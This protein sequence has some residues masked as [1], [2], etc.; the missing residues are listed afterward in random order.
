VSPRHKNTSRVRAALLAAV[1]VTLCLGPVT[2]EASLVI[3]EV[4]SSSLH[5]Q[6]T[7]PGTGTANGDWWELTN[8][9]P[10]QVNV[11]GYS[12]ADAD[13]LAGETPFPAVSI[14]VGE[15]VVIVNENLDNIGGF[16]TA[17]GLPGSVV[18][19]SKDLFIGTEGFHKFSSNGDEVNLFDPDDT[20]VTMVSFGVANPGTTFEWARGGESLGYSVAGEYGAY[21]APGD[22]SG[23][24]GSDVG[25]PGFSV[26]KRLGDVNFDG[27]VN[28]LDVDPFV[29]RVL[30]G[31]YQAE[32][33]M[34]VDGL[35]NGL[36]VDPFVAAVLGIGGGVMAVPEPSTW[37]LIALAAAVGGLS[38]GARFSRRR[39]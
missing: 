27:E 16:R 15:S 29:D 24:P 2:G 10:A 37:I 38:C 11:G 36:D 26:N 14:A 19:L 35:V 12:W 25:S 22:G 28:G 39:A 3:T 6:E 23:G 32:A 8:T 34:N 1:A 13:G 4:M 7:T 17:W 21:M 9:G 30:S 5:P 18:T 31:T 33:D 20:L